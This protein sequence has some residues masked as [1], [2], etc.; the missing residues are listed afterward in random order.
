MSVNEMLF[1]EGD[2]REKGSEAA[3]SLPFS[4]AVHLRCFM[5]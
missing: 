4:L 1:M 3:A 2:A 5:N